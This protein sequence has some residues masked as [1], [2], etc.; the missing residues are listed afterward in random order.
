MYSKSAEWYDDIYSWKDYS[1]EAELLHALIQKH[2]RRPLKTLL[3]V[4]CGTGQHVRYLK[5]HYT[6]E[7]LEYADPMLARARRQHPDVTFHQ[8][9]MT[10]FELGRQFDVVVC[11]FASIAY[12][13]TT[14]RLRTALESMRRHAKPGGLVI[15]EPF[16]RPDQFK[17][18]HVGAIFVD[19]P[20]L[21]IARVHVS[22]QECGIAILAMHYLVGTPQGVEQFTELHE[23]A[24]FSH[25][26]YLTAYRAA[27][28]DVVY[29]QEGLMGRGLYIGI[30]PE[31]GGAA[32]TH[33]SGGT[34]DSLGGP[35][36]PSTRG[37]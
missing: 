17:T 1:R 35:M 2:S 12:A 4:A 7:G 8:G 10:G 31:P 29:D 27:G 28:L 5:T 23:L 3:D 9:D 26:E 24:L 19:R 34:P 6:V 32:P 21:K 11:L 37:Q 22:T 14:A 15:A 30:L 18:G 36:G 13:K 33:P 20:E 25:D 16:I